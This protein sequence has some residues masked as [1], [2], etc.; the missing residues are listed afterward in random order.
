MPNSETAAVI[1]AFDDLPRLAASKIPHSWEVF[2]PEDQLGTINRLNDH[3]VLSALTM[4]RTGRRI[5]LS[6]PLT[7]PD[8]PLFGRKPLEHTVYPGSRNSW[9]D[10]VDGF[11]PQGS[12]QWDSLRH[13]RA[14]EDGFYGGWGGEPDSEPAWLGIQNWAEVGII[15]RGVLLDVADSIRQDDP[16]YDPFS[17]YWIEANHLRV[18]AER[19]GTTL[20]AGDILCVRTGWMDDYLALDATARRDLS[21]RFGS[22]SGRAWAGL[23]GS[24]DM[25]RYLWDAQLSAVV[26]DNPA[27]EVAPGD[28]AVGSLHRRLIPALGFALGE[29]FDFSKLA[30]ACQE[31]GR[32]EFLFVSIPI[33][34]TGGVGSPANAIAIL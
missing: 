26:A 18:A 9:D 31:S 4:A 32:H 20:Q 27:V 22:V 10:R 19:Q 5:N 6:L 16:A 11:Y 15:G 29:L 24:E 8:P 3:T 2:G 1:A 17:R 13:I 28:P 12:S 34:L 25:S 30:A 33:N 7:L 23:S 14:R 21:A